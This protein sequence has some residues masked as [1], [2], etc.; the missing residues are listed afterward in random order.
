MRRFVSL[1]TACA[2]TLT[3]IVP[4]AASET[5][6]AELSVRETVLHEGA[7]LHENTFWS[8]TMSDLRRENYIV[9][10]P[11]S[12]VRPVVTNGGYVTAKQTVSA[13]AASLEAQGL[14]VVAGINGDYYSDK[15]RQ[16][17][18]IVRQG[19]VMRE[20]V[21]DN[22]DLLFIDELGDLHVFH[23]G[24]KEQQ[25]EVD[26]FKAEH[27]IVNAFCF[28][29]GLVIDGQ[30]Q[31]MRKDDI[32]DHAFIKEPRAGIG[33]LDTLTYIMVVV[34]GREDTTAGVTLDEFADIMH[35][36]GC[37]QAYNLDGG[38]SATLVFNGKIVNEKKA[39]ERDVQDIVYFATAVDGE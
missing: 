17:G 36:L 6:G 24:K 30:K 15:D 23:R 29:P 5:L 26:A 34:N 35:Q 13:A 22:F 37:K 39:A 27:E 1:L 16:G 4:A 11:N 8:D 14:R 20:R 10:A 21:S 19:Q 33:Q 3:L 2:L 12:R 32:W 38:N 25:A 7:T 18:H 9:Y 31:E 28:G